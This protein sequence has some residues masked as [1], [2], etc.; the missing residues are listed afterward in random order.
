M[1]ENAT[2]VWEWLQKGAYFYICGEA[3]SMAKDVESALLKII[4]NCGHLGNTQ[5]E[6]FLKMLKNTGRYQ[7]DVY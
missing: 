7:K 2:I 6:D 1:M 5:A 3:K 4:E